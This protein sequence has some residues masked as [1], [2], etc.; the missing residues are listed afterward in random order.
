MNISIKLTLT[1]K[2]TMSSG[3]GE[4]VGPRR[5]EKIKRFKAAYQL[6][7]S[8]DQLQEYMNIIGMVFSMC[9]LMMKVKL[10]FEWYLNVF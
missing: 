10:Q 4:I 8:D 6:Q 9:G 7:V 1:H 2:L 3:S 5:A